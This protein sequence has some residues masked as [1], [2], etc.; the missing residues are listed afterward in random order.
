MPGSTTTTQNNVIRWFFLLRRQLQR[1]QQ[2]PSLLLKA[3]GTPLQ[4][5]RVLSQDTPMHSPDT[6]PRT[7]PHT[8]RKKKSQPK[9]RPEAHEPQGAA[10]E[11]QINQVQQVQSIHGG[12]G[13]PAATV[14]AC[15]T[16]RAKQHTLPHTHTQEN[17]WKESMVSINHCPALLNS[18]SNLH[19]RG[20]PGKGQGLGSSGHQNPNRCRRN[21]RSSRGRPP[22]AA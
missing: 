13:R 1:Q 8:R 11:S 15:T 16:H 19:E 20:T 14:S 18:K 17:L 9:P 3:L 5:R 10:P 2:Q 7:H 21:L 6:H 22:H 4:H 12:R